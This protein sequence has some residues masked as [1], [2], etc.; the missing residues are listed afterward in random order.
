MSIEQY[1]SDSIERGLTK[2]DAIKE[3]IELT[4]GED[5]ERNV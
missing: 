4:K 3:Y 2:I 5:D 1:I